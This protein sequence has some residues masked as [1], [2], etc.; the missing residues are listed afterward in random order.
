MSRSKFV[1]TGATRGDQVAVL[2]G[3]EARRYRRHRGAD[4]AAQRL[5]GDDRQQ[6]ASRPFSAE[7]AGPNDMKARP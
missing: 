6:G 1:T 4:E 7:S 5:A 3:V 2:S